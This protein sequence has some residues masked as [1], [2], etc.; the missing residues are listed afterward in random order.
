MGDRGWLIR[1]DLGWTF[2]PNGH[3]LYLGLDHGEVGGQSS[4]MLVGTKLTGAVLGVRGSIKGVAYD[5]FV[6]KP[7]RK[8]DNFRSSNGV[9][10]FNLNWSY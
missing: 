5:V 2:D 7:I 10:G 3:E 6:G 9:A 4:A 8:P 1:N